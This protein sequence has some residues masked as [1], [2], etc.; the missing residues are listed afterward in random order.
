MLKQA[1][2]DMEQ[3]C[4]DYVLKEADVDDKNSIATL[5]SKWRCLVTTMKGLFFQPI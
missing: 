2:K 5:F 1:N 4:D 3:S